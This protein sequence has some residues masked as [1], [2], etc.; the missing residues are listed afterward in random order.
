MSAHYR[1]RIG[2]FKGTFDG[3]N[4]TIS[5]LT[6]NSSGDYVGLFGSFISGTV[7]SD[8]VTVNNVTYYASP[9]TLKASDTNAIIQSTSYTN[10]TDGTVTVTPTADTNISNA[11]GFYYAVSVPNCV[12]SVSGTEAE[13]DGTKYYQNGST[14]TLTAKTGYVVDNVT[15]SS[16]TSITATV[17]TT[18]HYAFKDGDGYTYA[19]NANVAQKSYPDLTRVYE[20]N[21]PEGVTVMG[22]S[23]VAI[24]GTTYAA[25]NGSDTIN[26][27]NGDS[28]YL[29]DITLDEITIDTVTAS[30]VAFSFS[31]GGKLTVN[32]NNSGVTFTVGNETYRLNGNRE[33]ERK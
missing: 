9:V 11:I 10:N 16:D 30:A 20:L 17:D 8:T 24:D 21:L 2:S 1:T 18:N 7:T 13:V 4:K 26:A 12:Q 29:V 23:V 3:D 25:G 19:T 14:L 22:D 33:F 27:G 15:V 31:D 6:I 28:V 5:N 32:D